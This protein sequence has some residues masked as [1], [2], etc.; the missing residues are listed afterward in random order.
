[1][2]LH[3]PVELAPFFGNLTQPLHL[4]GEYTVRLTV[5]GK[6]YTQ[7]ALVAPD[8]RGAKPYDADENPN[9]DDDNN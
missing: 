8:P 3:R 4:R 2:V 9:N 6:T 7:P 1:M 5:D